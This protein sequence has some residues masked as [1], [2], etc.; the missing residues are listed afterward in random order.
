MKIINFSY[1]WNNKLDCKAFTT[2]R[3]SDKYNTNDIIEIHLKK[4]LLFKAEVIQK[5]CLKLNLINHW[6][7]YIDT[8]YNAIECQELLKKM[9]KNKNINWQNQSIYFYLLQKLQKN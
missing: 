5:K 4:K 7:A 3:L 8:G 1:N 9:Y 6:I 2:L